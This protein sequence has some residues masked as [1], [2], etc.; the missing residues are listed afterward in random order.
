[1]EIGSAKPF[2]TVFDDLAGGSRAQCRARRG[3]ADQ[4]A[5]LELEAADID[6]ENSE[7]ACQSDDIEVIEAEPV[8]PGPNADLRP[9]PVS[10]RYGTY[11]PVEHCTG[12]RATHCCSPVR[13][14]AAAGTCST[15]RSAG[16]PWLSAL[17][18]VGLQEVR[19]HDLRHTRR[20]A[21][22]RCRGHPQR[23]DDAP[24]AQRVTAS[25]TISDRCGPRRR[26]H[27]QP[28]EGMK[29]AA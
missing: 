21:R 26:D 19:V 9:Q 12:R 28:C 22:H 17:K 14:R 4:P 11:P 27:G 10:R 8:E 6:T 15:R 25:L 13:T 16:L 2:E 29:S 3:G 23:A 24:G 7:S 5:R 20:D 1:V 18:A